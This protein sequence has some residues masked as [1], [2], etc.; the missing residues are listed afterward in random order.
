M[1]DWVEYIVQVISTSTTVQADR[2]KATNAVTQAMKAKAKGK[3]KAV[4]SGQRGKGEVTTSSLASEH[5][6]SMFLVK[7]GET[8]LAQPE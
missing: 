3:G 8:Y 2:A 1:E 7:I 4:D 5:S 6:L